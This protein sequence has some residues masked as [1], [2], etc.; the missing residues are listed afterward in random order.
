[1]RDVFHAAS[2]EVAAPAERAFE[3]LSDGV[4][5]GEWTLGSWDRERIGG[6]LFRGRSLYN[7]SE[8]YVRI[9]RYPETLTVDYEVGPSPEQLTRRI[10][11]RVVPGEV[12][13]RDAGTCV[14]ALMVWRTPDQDEAA[15][16]QVG[17]IHR[18]EMHLIKGRLELGF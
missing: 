7:G 12:V 11:A 6:D 4:R 8:V 1:M 18:A 9:T 17:E 16:R 14:V 10:S 2:A 13:K 15:W 3:Y 5:Q